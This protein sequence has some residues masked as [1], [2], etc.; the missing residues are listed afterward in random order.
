LP[1]VLPLAAVL[2]LVTVPLEP[3]EEP[4]PEE[5]P[6][7]LETETLAFADQIG[8]GRPAVS[9][10]AALEPRSQEIRV[11][12]GLGGPGYPDGNFD[13]ARVHNRGRNLGFRRRSDCRNHGRPECQVGA[14]SDHYDEGYQQPW[15]H[16]SLVLHVCFPLPATAGA[17]RLVSDLSRI[18]TIL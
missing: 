14:D 9:T 6:D 8:T 4:D 15:P 16:T 7:V 2:V 11:V 3:N 13:R 17:A 12:L 5:P 1:V 18:Q 10:P